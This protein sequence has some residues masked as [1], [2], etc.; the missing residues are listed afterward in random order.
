MPL[1]RPHLPVQLTLYDVY[2][3][4]RQLGPVIHVT[5]NRCITLEMA[6]TD[7]TK[8]L[9]RTQ[10]LKC[11]STSIAVYAWQ[12]EHC[13]RPFAAQPPPPPY[14]GPRMRSG[15]VID[16]LNDDCLREICR[17]LEAVDLCA[18]AQTCLRFNAAARHA[19]RAR[20]RR[21]KFVLEPNTWP[22]P[23]AE[24]LLRHF[25][26]HIVAAEVHDQLNAYA[27]A[28][29]VLAM[30]AYH[31]RHIGYLECRRLRPI[32]AAIERYGRLR[33]AA[34]RGPPP[35]G[36]LHTL[37]INSER[38]VHA[39]VHI[40]AAI[41]LPALSELRFRLCQIV[42]AVSIVDFLDAHAHIRSLTLSGAKLTR[43][44]IEVLLDR[45]PDLHE[46]HLKN[47]HWREDAEHA[48]DRAYA[49]FGRLS[50]LR[51]FSFDYVDRPVQPLFAAMRAGGLRLERLALKWTALPRSMGAMQSIK[52]LDYEH[53]TTDALPALTEYIRS[54]RCLEEIRLKSSHITLDWVRDILRSAAAQLRVAQ[55]VK[56]LD[57]ADQHFVQ[58]NV[59]QIEAIDRIVSTGRIQ[60]QVELVV[61]RCWAG[62][63]VHDEVL[64]RC[65][66]WLCS[67]YNTAYVHLAANA[68]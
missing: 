45:L 37:T 59:S 68:E 2:M 11:G 12:R 7:R 50:R 53:W 6:D 30:I 38:V 15:S 22:I 8:Q 31:C 4:F 62:H 56:C 23:R 61:H 39:G 21:A 14:V 25:G 3:A 20:Y 32:G 10:S 28:D 29:I 52:C 48:E 44:H 64:A 46:L 60:V 18:I 42:D 26:Q 9:K 49:C 66:K 5:G 24:V 40:A 17:Q 34:D 27:Y 1:F 67:S 63:A 54:D 16:A 36:H 13:R 47:C 41:K 51:V 33:A 55:F 65:S 19:F 58:N 43:A 57:T 35:F